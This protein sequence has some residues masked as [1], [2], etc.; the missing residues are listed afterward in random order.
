VW[1]WSSDGRRLAIE[2]SYD[3][4]DGDFDRGRR[5]GLVGADGSRFRWVHEQEGS[6]GFD[7]SWS[8]DGRSIVFECGLSF[9]GDVCV[10]DAATGSV[11]NLTE[12]D[13]RGEFGG[14]WS[15][16][17]DVIAFIGHGPDPRVDDRNTGIFVVRAAGGSPLRLTQLRGDISWS[18]DGRW[19]SLWSGSTSPTLYVVAVDGRKLTRIARLALREAWQPRPRR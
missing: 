18:P 4:Q 7:I 15:P 9:R 8:P 11:R 3:D 6:L 1:S 17:G 13:D 16:R 10:A 12:T 19:I 2:E 5:I 14:A